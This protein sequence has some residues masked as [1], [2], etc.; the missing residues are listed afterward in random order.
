[1]QVNV[2]QAKARLSELI[3]KAMLGEEVVIAKDN[4][5]LLRLVPVEALA[6]TRIPGTAKHQIVSLAPDFDQTP[7]DF[8][9][10]Q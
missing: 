9:D 7:D 1:M 2:A 6:S 8:N 10:Y 4:K 5:P 3:Q